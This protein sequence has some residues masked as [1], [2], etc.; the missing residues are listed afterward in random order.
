[1]AAVRVYQKFGLPAPDQPRGLPASCFTYRCE[2]L[3]LCGIE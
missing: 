2:A 1:M 3:R